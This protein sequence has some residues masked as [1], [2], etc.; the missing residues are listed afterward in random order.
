MNI[1]HIHIGSDTLKIVV[2]LNIVLTMVA[3]CSAD[4]I[5]CAKF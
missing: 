4:Y 1:S 5:I 3:G 2:N